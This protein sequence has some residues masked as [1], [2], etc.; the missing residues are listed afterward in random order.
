LRILFEKFASD[1]SVIIYG[2]P[3]A[4]LLENAKTRGIDITIFS[5]LEGL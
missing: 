3:S 4:E 5:F 1:H 2:E